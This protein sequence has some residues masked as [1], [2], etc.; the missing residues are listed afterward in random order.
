MLILK[1]FKISLQV[2]FFF[3]QVLYNVLEI[4]EHKILNTSPF[5]IMLK[6]SYLKKEQFKD[7]FSICFFFFC[8]PAQLPRY[9]V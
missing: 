3:H 6:I 8:L 4:F 7:P 2:A 1:S 9:T 5:Q